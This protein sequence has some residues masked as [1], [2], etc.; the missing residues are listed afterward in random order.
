MAVT[1][2]WHNVYT[3]S[4]V[5]GSHLYGQG[6]KAT[7]GSLDALNKAIGAR[8]DINRANWDNQKNL[9]TQSAINQ[10][11]SATTMDDYNKINLDEVLKPFGA[12]VDTQAVRNAYNTQDNAIKKDYAETAAYQELMRKETDTPIYNQAVAALGKGDMKTAKELTGKLQ[13][14]ELA[15]SMA[16]KLLAQ[17]NADRQ[18][19]LQAASAKRAQENADRAYNLQKKQGE[20]ALANAIYQAELKN[21]VDKVEGTASGLKKSLEE[22][23]GVDLAGMTRAMT[24]S[25]ATPGDAVKL[26][27]DTEDLTRINK[28]MKDAGMPAVTAA[29]LEEIWKYAQADNATDLITTDTAWDG[30][31]EVGTGDFIKQLG[32][33]R[34]Y[35]EGASA[36]DAIKSNT[37]G[38][39]A[40]SAAKARAS[41]SKG[42]DPGSIDT[43]TLLQ[44]F[45][46]K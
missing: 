3:P 46:S 38:E 13:S 14:Q 17:S 31:I 12:Q 39:L 33:Y 1:P 23:I 32:K 40:V 21:T 9:N 36:I 27:F 16:G 11:T 41:I 34:Q 26:G 18:F 5:S 42:K 8:G 7:M 19:G 20:D 45:G 10:I 30:N 22:Q 6:A 24:G 43:A 29:G 4:V 37:L 2:T 25:K 15:T 35:N 44:R 28:A